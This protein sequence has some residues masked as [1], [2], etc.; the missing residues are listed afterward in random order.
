MPAEDALARTLP[1][2]KTLK[3]LINREIEEAGGRMPD[4]QAFMDKLSEQTKAGLFL[5]NDIPPIT[6]RPRRR[7]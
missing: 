6:R 3:E 4:M 5:D 2:E 7:G 1:D